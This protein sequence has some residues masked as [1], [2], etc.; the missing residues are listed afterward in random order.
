[1]EKESLL[2]PDSEGGLS[3]P[4]RRVAALSFQS[5]T[6]QCELLE[7]WNMTYG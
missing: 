3:C 2:F 4:D 7:T 6:A 5:L 1:M